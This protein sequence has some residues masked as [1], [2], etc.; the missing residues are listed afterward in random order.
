MLSPEGREMGIGE[1]I[2]NSL[3]IKENR[4]SIIFSKEA[5]REGYGVLLAHIASS[6]YEGR[7]AVVVEN[8]EDERI[9]KE[10]NLCLDKD[11]KIL[12]YENVESAAADL[13]AKGARFIKYVTLEAEAEK[14]YQY[15]NEIIIINKA[16]A[17][18]GK[19]HELNEVIEEFKSLLKAEYST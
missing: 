12:L 17:G 3:G 14:K 13:K 9:V 7:I 15:I 6:L 8:E 16:L 2:V 10:L 5:V 4:T 11:N 1:M 19:I 18:M